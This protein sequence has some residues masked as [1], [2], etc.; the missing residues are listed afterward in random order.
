MGSPIDP[1]GNIESPTVLLQRLHR[2]RMAFFGLVILLAG[3]LLG[4]AGT[5]LTVP[6]A[7]PVDSRPPDFAVE[8]MLHRIGPR[9]RLSTQQ[10]GQIRPILRKHTEKLDR[11]REEGR[12]QIHDQLRLM[13]EEIAKVLD[14]DQERLWHE[15]LRGLPGQFGRG[16]GRY[17]PG[18]GS[19]PG[20]RLGPRYGRPGPPQRPSPNDPPQFQEPPASEQ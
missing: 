15:F 13:N 1:N 14:Q 12:V 19:G 17:G 6:R 9:L 16:P 4:I 5:L 18:A 11:I 7:R 3:A 8:E 20:G 10:A 2:W